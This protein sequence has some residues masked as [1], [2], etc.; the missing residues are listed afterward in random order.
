M[1]LPYL[2]RINLHET[3]SFNVALRFQLA[4]ELQKIGLVVLFVHLPESARLQT[5]I[6]ST[7][8]RTPCRPPGDT[9][10]ALQRHQ[11]RSI[12]IEGLV[13][14]YRHLLQQMYVVR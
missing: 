14:G 13:C 1:R 6:G 7:A 12:Y 11:Q 5:A 4:P 9:A 3:I 2:Q 10:D 8:A